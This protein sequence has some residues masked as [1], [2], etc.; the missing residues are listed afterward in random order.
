MIGFIGVFEGGV[1]TV[2]ATGALMTVAG[3]DGLFAICAIFGGAGSADIPN[4]FP[5]YIKL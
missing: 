2:L 5:P 4:C 1:T 3:L